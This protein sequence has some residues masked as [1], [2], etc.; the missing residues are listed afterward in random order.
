MQLEKWPPENLE[1]AWKMRLRNRLLAEGLKTDS[2]PALTKVRKLLGPLP[3]PFSPPRTGLAGERE[4]V[5]LGSR[6]EKGVDN[7]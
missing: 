2:C 3:L 7:N 1:P 5:G 4:R 6:L